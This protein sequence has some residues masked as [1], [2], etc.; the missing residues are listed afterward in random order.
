MATNLINYSNCAGRFRNV[1]RFFIFRAVD[2]GGGGALLDWAGPPVL[3]FLAF[4]LME[5]V[6]AWLC[7]P[8]K[9]LTASLKQLQPILEVV[10]NYWIKCNEPVVAV[11]TV[12]FNDA[13]QN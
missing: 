9:G 11:V 5:A 2:G 6:A 13:C 7:I 3:H 10:S 4:C 12:F 8:T 1:Y